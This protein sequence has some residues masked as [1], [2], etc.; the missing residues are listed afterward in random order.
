[1]R[2]R[3]NNLTYKT[4]RQTTGW[5]PEKANPW[6]E[7]KLG[8]PT[9]WDPETIYWTGESVLD[10]DD[11]VYEALWWTQNAKPSENVNVN[12]NGKA[13]KIQGPL[14]DFAV[15]KMDDLQEFSPEVTYAKGNLVQYDQKAYE[16]SRDITLGIVPDATNPWVYSMNL[17]SVSAKVGD[18]PNSWPEQLI[19]PYIDG[20]MAVPDL[21]AYAAETGIKH[22]VLAF[23][24]N[25]T[26]SDVC[27]I[28]WGVYGSAMSLE[29]G[30]PGLYKKIKALRAA[31]GD[32]T[33]SIG[34]ANNA[35]LAGTCKDVNQIADVYYQ[36]ATSFNLRVLDFDI[37]GMWVSDQPSIDRRSQALKILQ[38]RLETE[39]RELEIWITLPILPTGL[40]REGINVLQSAIDHNVVVSAVNVMAMDYGFATCQSAGTEGS[41]IHGQCGVDAMNS[42]KSQLEGLYINRADLLPDKLADDIAKMILVTPMIGIND[43]GGESFF[44]SDAQY[45]GSEASKLGIRGLSFWSLLR[46]RPGKANLSPTHSGM[47]YEENAFARA[48]ENSFF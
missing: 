34:G 10:V 48:F 23:L 43:V 2:L 38:D 27:S 18:N 12:Y 7:R 15:L 17:S 41:N 8:T 21:E 19:V 22:F 37:E 13:W 24:T 1:M 46:D 31:S 39:G 11:M 42:L 6:Q 30:P 36:I 33:I 29:A 26:V 44:I 5:A 47:K 45:V 4:T 28:S 14:S 16:A 35:P 40:T 9:Q 20:T 32:V 3:F 25:P